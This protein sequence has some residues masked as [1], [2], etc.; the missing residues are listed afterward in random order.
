MVTI[1]ILVILGTISLN[2]LFNK[3][4]IIK[5][6]QLAKEIQTNAEAREKNS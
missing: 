4:G 6:A 3:N 2:L 5:Q 1:V